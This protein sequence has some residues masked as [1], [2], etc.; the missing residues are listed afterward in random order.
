MAIEPFDLSIPLRTA[1]IGSA[2]ITAMLPAYN[3][4][5]PVFTRRPTPPDAPYP[6]IVVS[7]D[8]TLGDE[9]GINFYAPL[10]RRDVAVYHSNE[11]PENY[12]LADDIGYAVRDLF[13]RRRH[14]FT[15][16][17]WDV[18]RVLAAVPIP[19]ELPQLQVTGRIVQL[20]VLLASNGVAA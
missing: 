7:Q 13:H 14:V 20:S 19:V 11:L 3:D 17:D 8:I 4:S 5:F 9:D 10:I 12:R 18:V 2:T 15:V 16:D 6:M 1:I